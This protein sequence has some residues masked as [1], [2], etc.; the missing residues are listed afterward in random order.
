MQEKK[1]KMAN[2]G[3]SPPE[4][5]S[6]AP[7]TPKHLEIVS[8]AYNSPSLP[9]T[10]QI[11]GASTNVTGLTSELGSS[12]QTGDIRSPTRQRD[13]TPRRQHLGND[14]GMDSQPST[15]PHHNAKR[16]LDYPNE[17]QGR[18]ENSPLYRKEAQQQ[19]WN[20]HQNQMQIKH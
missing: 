14:T 1:Q 19:Q 2:A 9:R 20:T 17:A 12:P 7:G 15:P 6:P 11:L 5:H 10:N 16:A 13:G 8:R 3:I 18:G 4:A